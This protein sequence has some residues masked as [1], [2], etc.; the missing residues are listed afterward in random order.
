MNFLNQG[1]P[2]LSTER[3]QELLQGAYPYVYRSAK[4]AELNDSNLHAYCFYP[5]GHEPEQ[6]NAELKPAIVFF[7]GGHWDVSMVT[8]FS[9]HAMHFASRGMVAI[10]VEYRVESTHESS[11]DEA[12]ED[13]ETLMLWL[14][15]NHEDLRIDPDRI[16]VAGAACGA[17]MALSLAMR[18]KKSPKRGY[19]TG[20]DSQPQAVIAVSAV[21]SASR[22]HVDMKRFP[23]ARQASKNHPIYNIRRKLPP[24]LM[25]HGK[26]DTI[27]AHYLVEDFVKA[28]RRKRNHCELIDFDACNHSFFNFNVSPEHFEITLNTMDVFVAQLGYIPP[29][30]Y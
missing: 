14:R 3:K 6:M 11:P 13:A 5:P 7:H 2:P 15:Y 28:M 18:K 20:F 23:N 9:P 16:V 8:Q 24:T 29:V 19:A 17:H 22:K 4:D 27:A 1:S 21:V 30:E 26:A 12:F 10:V 25:I